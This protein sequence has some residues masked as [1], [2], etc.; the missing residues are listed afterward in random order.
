[1]VE[2][3][4]HNSKA[5]KTLR[6]IKTRFMALILNCFALFS[7]I[8]TFRGYWYLLDSYYFPHED[9]YEISLITGQ[10]FGALVLIAM[11]ATCSLHAGVFKADGEPSSQLFEFYYSSYFYLKVSSCF[12]HAS[13][14]N[15]EFALFRRK[16]SLNF[17]QW[18]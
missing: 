15:N 16:M 12:F 4:C 9:H 18:A 13:D 17:H 7:T 6:V 3:K 14:S 8:N 2:P 5:S 10:L 11:N 1:M